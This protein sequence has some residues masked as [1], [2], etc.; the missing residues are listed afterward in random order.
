MVLTLEPGGTRVGKDIRRI[1]LDSRNTHL[2]PLAELMLYEADR[3][4]HMQEVIGPALSEGKWVL[5]DRFFDSTMVY[6]GYARGQ[7][8]AFIADLNRTCASGIFPDLTFVVDCPVRIGIE[9]ALKRNKLI[10][11]EGQD[12]FEKEQRIFHEAVRKGFLKIAAEDPERIVVV[13]GTLSEDEL[14]K[15]IFEKVRPFLSDGA[16]A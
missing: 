7:D 15:V 2:T 11:D 4:Q 10:M 14:E 16:E 5:C 1:L 6:Q 13:D 9:R 8:T 3:A 12:R